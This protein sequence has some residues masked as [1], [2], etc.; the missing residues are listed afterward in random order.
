MAVDV[1]S[2][3]YGPSGHL[4]LAELPVRTKARICSLADSTGKDL[5]KLLVFGLLPGQSVEVLQRYPAIVV[6]VGRTTIALDEQVA[7]KVVVKA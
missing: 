1:L 7:S 5:Q 2:N 4:S 3:T 6:Q